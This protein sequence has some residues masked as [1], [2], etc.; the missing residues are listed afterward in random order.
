MKYVRKK[1]GGR[2]TNDAYPT[3]SS[4]YDVD[5]MCRCIMRTLICDVLELY[6]FMI[7]G[8]TERKEKTPAS[9]G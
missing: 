1:F 6:M 4:V 2:S 9:G 5:Y 3:Y 8:D 7:K